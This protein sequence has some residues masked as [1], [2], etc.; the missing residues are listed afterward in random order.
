MGFFKQ[1]S[2][3]LLMSVGGLFLLASV[4]ILFDRS[5]EDRASASMGCVLLGAPP[6]ALGAWLFRS[7][8][9]QTQKQRQAQQAAENQRLQSVLYQLIEQKQ[10]KFTLIE[11]A[12]AADLSGEVARD[13]LQDQARAFGADFSVTDQ[14]EIV[15]HFISQ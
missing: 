7:A 6:A 2:G 11:F 15:Y 1:L 5:E 13:Y 10:G 4:L 3:A 8:Q 12:M 9:A 14:G